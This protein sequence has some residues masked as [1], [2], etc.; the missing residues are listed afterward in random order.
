MGIVNFGIPLEDAGYLKKKM[1]LDVAVEGGTYLGGTAT[2]LSRIFR[3]VYTIEN[4]DQIYEKAIKNISSISNIQLLKGDTRS[5]LPKI[6]H[7]EN[8]ILFWLDAHWSGGETYGESDECPLI[9]EL[10][11]IFESRITCAI[12]IDDARL[13]MAPPP[14]PHNEK[15]WPSCADISTVIP[16][17]WD[18][19]I[20][21]DVIYLTPKSISFRKYM[22]EKATNDWISWGKNNYPSLGNCFRG[23]L[24]RLRGNRR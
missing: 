16:A 13:F 23:L 19:I 7:S 18:L 3:K 22:Q 15:T 12:L 1:Q 8:K 2:I 14:M 9:E 4:S 21:D 10:R 6:V 17:D 5:H 24:R 20:Y 11:I